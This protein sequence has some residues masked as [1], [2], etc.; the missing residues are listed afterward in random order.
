[1]HGRVLHELLKGE[2]DTVDWKTTIHE[3][4]TST[5]SGQFRQE[6][7]V[8]SVGETVYVNYGTGG[9]QIY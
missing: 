7:S 1:M 4:T 3:A 6:V 5:P 8:S 2:P 9:L